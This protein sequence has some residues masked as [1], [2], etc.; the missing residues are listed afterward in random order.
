MHSVGHD[1]FPT[2]EQMIDIVFEADIS[3]GAI[4]S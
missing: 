1:V 3:K 4:L 2:K